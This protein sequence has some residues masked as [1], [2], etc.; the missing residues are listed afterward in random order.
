MA[1]KKA[2]PKKTAVL[3][4]EKIIAA[5]MD[6][7]LTYEKKP[8]TVYGFCKANDFDEQ[9]FYSFFGNLEAVEKG[10]WE[11]FYTQ[12]IQ[13][14][15]KGQD[16]SAS[17]SREKMLGFFFSFFELL[18]LNRSYVLYALRRDK[19]ML[20]N[21]MALKGLRKHFKSFTTDLIELDNSSAQ[22]K[23]TQFQPAIFSEAAWV[24]LLFTLKF[25]MEDGSPSF[26]KTD[27]LIEKSINT[28]FDVFN[29][30]PLEQVFDLGK[31]LY[32]ERMA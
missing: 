13:L 12:T 21:L 7:V 20:H 32:K 9:S 4:S 30:T 1:T 24:Q 31:F 16:F 10:I 27:V 26:E 22:S 11:A 25:W 5:Y 28:V 15:E 6:H 8:L 17:T 14:L 19:N 23:L 29:S 18:T 3:S 2:T